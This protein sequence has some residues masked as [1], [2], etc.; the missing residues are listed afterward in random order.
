MDTSERGITVTPGAR[1][2]ARD[3][4]GELL[5]RRAVTAVE[6]ENGRPVVWVCKESEWDRAENEGRYP[7]AFPWPAEDVVVP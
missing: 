3:A 2:L 5:E 7:N 1:V 4:E 6:V